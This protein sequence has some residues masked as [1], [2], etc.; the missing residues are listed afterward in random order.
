[1][2]SSPV[3][4]YVQRKDNFSTEETPIPFDLERLN[5]GG[6][7]NLESGIFTA[8]RDGIYSFSFVGLVV[9]PKSSSYVYLGVTMYLNGRMIGLGWADE[10]TDDDQSETLSLQSTLNLQKGDKIWLQINVM[11]TGAYLYGGSFT[12]FSGWL[13]EENM[14]Q[15]FNEI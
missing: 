5:V 9:F 3:Y 12:H 8:P 10:S 14:S 15:P 2:K 1:M 6:A 13:L 11:T 7:M 4:F